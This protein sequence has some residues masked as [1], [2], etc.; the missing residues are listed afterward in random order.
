MIRKLCCFC[1][2]TYSNYYQTKLKIHGINPEIAYEYH[3][4]GV[5]YQMQEQNLR[6]RIHS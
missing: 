1:V 2:H 6:T 4:Y 3:F 5:L